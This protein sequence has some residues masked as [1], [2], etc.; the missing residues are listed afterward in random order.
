MGKPSQV[1]PEEVGEVGEV[2]DDDRL[3]W[4]GPA[5]LMSGEFLGGWK[6]CRDYQELCMHQVG[7]NQAGSGSGG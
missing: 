2:G 5:C 3:T 4:L 6:D 7:R 1:E